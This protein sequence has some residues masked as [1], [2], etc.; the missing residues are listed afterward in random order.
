[1]F[2]AI[3]MSALIYL[4]IKLIFLCIKI[5]LKKLLYLIHNS[6]LIT[7]CPCGRGLSC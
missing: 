5:G 6:N 3:I 1:M 2:V 4:P 7:I